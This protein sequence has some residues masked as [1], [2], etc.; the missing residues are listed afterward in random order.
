M[1]V[2]IFVGVVA[3]DL[4]ARRRGVFPVTDG[5][6]HNL[7]LLS[8]RLMTTISAVRNRLWNNTGFF[9]MAWAFHYFPIL[10]YESAIIHTSLPYLHICVRV[11]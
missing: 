9:F 5:K 7:R 8:M 11:W 3:A 1:G 10:S 6:L 2:S 4:L